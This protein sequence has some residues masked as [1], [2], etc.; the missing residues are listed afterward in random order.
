VE[1]RVLLSNTNAIHWD[2]IRSQ[3][4]HVLELFDRLVVS[5]ECG[6]EKP[7]AAIFR[8]VE[9]GSGHPPAAHLFIDDIRENVEGALAVGWDAVQHIDA[10]RLERALAARGLL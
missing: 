9:E 2:W 7:D 3:Y 5:H 4:A 10:A 8:L 6:L 1:Q